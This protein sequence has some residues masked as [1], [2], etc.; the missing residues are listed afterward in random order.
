[1][2]LL[3]WLDK[4]AEEFLLLVFLIVMVLV[5]GVQVLMRYTLNYS[6]TWSEELTRYLFVWSAFISIGY[7]TKYG[8]SIK[9]EQLLKVLPD[10]LSQ[11]IR[12]SSKFIMLAFFIYVLKSSISVVQSSYASGQVSSALGLPIYMVQASTVVGFSLAIFRIVQSFYLGIVDMIGM[13]K[14]HS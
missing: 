11:I 13:R 6:L 4:N 5:M 2:K 3:R 10:I 14:Q 7:C 12:L 8:T 9:L 1:M